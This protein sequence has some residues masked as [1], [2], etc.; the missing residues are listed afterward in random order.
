MYV[1][2]N[3]VHYRKVRSDYPQDI[4]P[5]AACKRTELGDGDTFFSVKQIVIAIDTYYT[6]CRKIAKLLKGDTLQATCRNI[7]QFLIIISN[8]RPIVRNSNYAPLLAPG[9]NAL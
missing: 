8:I 6:Q 7:H 3:N 9:H 4:F 1:S 5:K 2:L